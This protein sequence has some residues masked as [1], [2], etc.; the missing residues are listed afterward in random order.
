VYYFEK[1]VILPGLD[2]Q[3]GKCKIQKIYI[4]KKKFNQIHSFIIRPSPHLYF[5]LFYFSLSLF[6]DDQGNLKVTSR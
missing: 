6:H 3:T 1:F 4:Q 5:Y 2:I